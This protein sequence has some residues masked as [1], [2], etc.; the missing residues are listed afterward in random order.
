MIRSLYDAVSSDE[1]AWRGM[2]F[3]RTIVNDGLGLRNRAAVVAYYIIPELLRK[4]TKSS[5]TIAGP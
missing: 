2:N 3:V 5:V 1:F 4:T